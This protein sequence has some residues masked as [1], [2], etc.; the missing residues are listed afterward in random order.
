M[1]KPILV[2]NG[3]NLNLLGQREP[4]VYGSA[5][6]SDIEA[7]TL[8]AAKGRGLDVDFRQSNREGELVDWVQWGRNGASGLIVNAGA[9]S[10]TSIA[11]LDAL[12]AVE[13]PV[14]EV[15]LS[16]IFRREEFRTHSYVSLA[17]VGVI[18]GLGVKGYELA[19]DALADQLS[20]S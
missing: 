9:Y 5:T 10:H 4:E 14:I 20:R 19:V 13:V 16:N 2:L 7:V 11:L 12:N 17:A 3:P 18:C 8:N 6:L 1:G 15:H